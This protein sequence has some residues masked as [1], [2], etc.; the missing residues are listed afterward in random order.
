ME[1]LIL[2]HRSGERR[3]KENMS[4]NF[5]FKKYMFTLASPSHPHPQV[6][7]GNYWTIT[8][9]SALCLGP[10]LSCYTFLPYF[11]R[12]SQ[13]IHFL[14]LFDC[15]LSEPRPWEFQFPH[16]V[17]TA[18][19]SNCNTFWNVLDCVLSSLSFSQVSVATNSPLQMAIAPLLPWRIP[20]AFCFTISHQLH[21][22]FFFF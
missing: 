18:G 11:S 7:F 20:S 19:W 13:A 22:T 1:W 12:L 8:A 16:T 5:S 6:L 9:I 3:E 21:E 17:S 15:F 4:T 2:E 10:L 14:N